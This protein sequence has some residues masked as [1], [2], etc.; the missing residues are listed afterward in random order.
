MTES[1]SS[2]FERMVR[3]FLEG[4]PSV[5]HRWKEV[6]SPWWGPRKDLIFESPRPGVSSVFATICDGQITVG[7]ATDDE[8]FER[9]GRKLSEMEVAQLAFARLVQLLREGGYLD[10]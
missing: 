4:H 1:L 7:T 8:D 2:S 9:F 10:A 5:Q 3:E 6:P